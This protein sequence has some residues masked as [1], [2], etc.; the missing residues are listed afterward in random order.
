MKKLTIILLL[1]LPILGIGQNYAVSLIPDSLLLNAHAVKRMEEIH[2]TIKSANKVI[3]KHKYA[4]TI[5]DE[6][7]DDYSGYE[8]YYSSKDSKVE[9]SQEE[10]S[11]IADNFSNEED[12]D[13]D[14]LEHKIENTGFVLNDILLV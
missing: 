14:L 10:E 11:L 12:N 4:I 3:V 2:L 7:G 13:K 6:E 5:L 9:I 8:N 1:F